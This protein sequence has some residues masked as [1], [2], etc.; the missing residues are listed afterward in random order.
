[1][2]ENIIIGADFG[3]TLSSSLK[4]FLYYELGLIDL[5]LIKNNIKK[6][7]AIKMSKYI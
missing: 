7:E 3:K 4:N 5:V 6:M 2:Y 1:M